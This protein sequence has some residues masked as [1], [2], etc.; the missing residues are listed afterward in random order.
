[1]GAGLIG[2]EHAS[3]VRSHPATELVGIADVS[4]EGRQYAESIGVPHFE[5]FDAMLEELRPHG[6]IVALPNT[7]H[8]TAGLA[9]IRRGIPSL[10]EKPIADTLEAARELVTKS[11]R[12]GV[13]VLI[14]H[15]RRHS[16]DIREAKRVISA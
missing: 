7:L 5:D 9:C 16:P 13:P 2:R 12:A 14:G 3:L 15:H 10:V 1:M 6:A 4:A 11:E 8:V